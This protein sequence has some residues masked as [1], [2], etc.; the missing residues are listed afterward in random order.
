[1]QTKNCL[2]RNAVYGTFSGIELKLALTEMKNGYNREQQGSL[3]LLKNGATGQAE[4]AYG[5]L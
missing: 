1:M 4:G 2:H 3:Y 5:R